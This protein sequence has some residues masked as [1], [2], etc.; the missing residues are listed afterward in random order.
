MKKP[1]N[2]YEA[3]IALERFKEEYS[4]EAMEQRIAAAA[5]SMDT[6]SITAAI[7]DRISAEPLYMNRATGE[8]LTGREM[9]EQGAALYDIDDPTNALEMAEY[10]K[11]ITL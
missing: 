6:D 1:A 3:A 10:Y 8:V 9:R 4:P 11:A 7:M 5:A 2:L